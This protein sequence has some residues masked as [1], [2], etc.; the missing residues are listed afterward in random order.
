MYLIAHRGNI[1]G[2]CPELENK[3]EYILGVLYSYSWAHCETD[4]WWIGG[5]FVL[6]HDKPQ[7]K[8]D[9]EFL[10]NAR[11]WCHAKNQSALVKMLKNPLIH[12]FWHQ[13]DDCTLTSRGYIWTYPGKSLSMKSICVLPELRGFPEITTAA[14]ICS[15]FIGEYK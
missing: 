5:E 14:G 7:Y 10:A 1:E 9:E 2:P 12:C 13:E 8:V 4:V 3:P 6:G 15:D 11:L